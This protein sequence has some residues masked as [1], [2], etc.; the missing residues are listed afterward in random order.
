MK[1]KKGWDNM[2]KKMVWWKSLLIAL[3]S[4]IGVVILVLS[5]YLIYISAQYYRIKDFQDITITNNQMGKLAV[6]SE[7]TVST[8]NIGFGAYSHDFSFFMDSGETLSGKKLSG[9]GS[10]AK[11]KKEVVKNTT[12]AVNTITPLNVDFALFQEV[13]VEG[14]RSHKYNQYKHIRN[15]FGEGYSS[16]I[17]MNFHSAF[18]F[19]PIFNPHGKTDAGIVTMSKYNISSATRRSLPIDETFPTKFFDLDRCIQVTRLPIESSDKQLVL[20]NVHLSA[21][22]KG[23]KIRKKQLVLLNNI[24]KAEKEA[25]NYVIAGGDFNHDIAD[26]IGAFP[27][28]RKVPEWVYVLDDSNLEQGYSFVSSKNAPTCRSTETSYKKGKNF[29]VVLDGFIVSDNVQM[30]SVENIDT[31]FKYSDHNPAV[32]TFKLI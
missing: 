18:L 14:T 26:S 24:F 15:S 1:V 22:D 23:G 28:T 11:S 25:G 7:Y 10:V 5:S 29:T 32:M 2:R 8:Y 12:G 31:D 6:G 3:A 13:D 21:Y 30:V 9:S 19:Y 27:T 4:I 17:S 16:S 20:I